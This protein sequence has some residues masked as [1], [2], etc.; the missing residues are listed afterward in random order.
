LCFVYSQL[1]PADRKW[2][3]DDGN[4]DINHGL[5]H[6]HRGVLDFVSSSRCHHNRSSI[7]GSGIHCV[8][9][10]PDDGSTCGYNVRPRCYNF[11]PRCYNC[12]TRCYN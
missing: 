6:D 8:F 9:R 3:D 7:D 1:R 5:V 2:G 10:S 11:H 4:D 12:C